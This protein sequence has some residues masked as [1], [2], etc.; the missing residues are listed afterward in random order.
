MQTA[1]ESTQKTNSELSANLADETASRVLFSLK[2]KVRDLRHYLSCEPARMSK[3]L[4][5]CVVSCTS[6]V[7]SLAS[8]L[9][10]SETWR[11]LLCYATHVHEILQKC[12]LHQA[13]TSCS[14]ALS[15]YTSS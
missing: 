5:V 4:K 13:L 2:S 7:H 9:C 12:V 1:L 3:M 8:N 14:A 10:L 6:T 15:C 11:A